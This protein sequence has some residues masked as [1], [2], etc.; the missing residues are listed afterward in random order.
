[1][2][3]AGEQLFNPLDSPVRIAVDKPS[4]P[5]E[6][7]WH[8]F[9]LL[10]AGFDAFF[11]IALALIATDPLQRLIHGHRTTSKPPSTFCIVV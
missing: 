9:S 7:L 8:D 1:V 3:A 6:K 5:V 11:G 10:A 2:L 4:G